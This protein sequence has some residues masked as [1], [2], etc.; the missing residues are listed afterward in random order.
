M[1]CGKISCCFEINS[2][3]W[4]WPRLFRQKQILTG[5]LVTK[6]LQKKWRFLYSFTLCLATFNQQQLP[7]HHIYRRNPWPTHIFNATYLEGTFSTPPRNISNL[8]L[9]WTFA[10][11]FLQPG[12]TSCAIFQ[13]NITRFSYCQPCKIFKLIMGL[14][15]NDWKHLKVLKNLF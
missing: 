11:R 2:K 6:N 8:P 3:F 14:I 7:C 12:L 5:L 15:L 1:L 4:S 10:A 9:L 13:K